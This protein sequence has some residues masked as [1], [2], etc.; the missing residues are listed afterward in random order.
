MLASGAQVG[1]AQVWLAAAAALGLALLL[2]R[3][4]HSDLARRRISNR[5]CLAV[6]LLA[7]PWWSG[8][9]PDPAAVLGRQL[10]LALVVALP[11]VVPFGLRLLGGGDV[12][13]IAALA[14]WLPP[15]EI[16]PMLLSTAL[17]GAAMGLAAWLAA[18][19]RRAPVRPV[20]YGLAIA[21]GTSVALAPAIGGLV[22]SL[23]PEASSPEWRWFAL[24]RGPT[25]P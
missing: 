11:L 6:A 14:L 25:L 2:A 17:C 1:E 21:V 16:V 23:R 18:R 19:L 10:A 20:P 24:D 5:T 13:L 8:L 15:G 3:A 22:A 12:K 9:A 4:V 7:V